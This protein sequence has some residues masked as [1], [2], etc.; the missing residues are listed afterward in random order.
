MKRPSRKSRFESLERRNLL[1]GGL[2]LGVNLP[3]VADYSAVAFVDVMKQAR[4]WQTTD[5]D[6]QGI[7]NSEHAD[8]IDLDASGWPTE[9][10]FTLDNTYDVTEPQIIHT[11]I[12]V[13]GE[14][15]YTF[16]A[17]GTGTV[18]IEAGTGLLDPNTPNIISQTISLSGTVDANGDSIPQQFQFE[19]FNSEYGDGNGNLFL[20]IN[21]SS[22]NDHLREMHLI[23]PG[24]LSDY[25][26]DPFDPT[27]TDD[28]DAFSNLRFMEWQETNNS[29]VV[30]VSDRTLTTD[31]TQSLPSGVAIEYIVDLANQLGQDP[32]ITIPAKAS[33]AYVADMADYLHANLN[34]GLKVFV[35]YSNETWNGA[36]NQAAYIQ[37]KGLALGLSTTS[38]EAGLRYHAMRSAEVWGIFEQSFGNRSSD[39][40]IK[41]IATQFVNIG[42]S[43]QLMAALND[44]TINPGGIM[45]DSLAIGAYFGFSI[46][47]KLV[48]DGTL[49]TATT[50]SIINSLNDELANQTAAD[51]AKQKAVADR[52][53]LWLITYE[54]GQHLA[55]TGTNVQ[56]TDLTNKL[57]AA[58]R[59]PLMG[60][61][62]KNYL[63]LLLAKG[64][65][66][67]SSF[68]YIY[69]P[70]QF[71]SWGLQENQ[72]PTSEQS[73]KYEAVVDWAFANPVSN[74]LPRANAG[75]DFALFDIGNDGENVT[76]DG[77]RSRDFDGT[78]ASYNWIVNGQSVST[79]S[80]FTYDA[81]IGITE[82]TL[83]VTDNDGGVSEDVIT[84]VLSSA[85]AIQTILDANFAAP[86]VN[87]VWSATNSLAADVEYSGFT[88]GSGLSPTST[89]NPQALTFT[90][91][92]YPSEPA[93]L[94]DAIVSNFYISFTIDPNSLTTSA[95]LDL[96]GAPM[97]FTV[98]RV[99]F[100]SARRFA[101]MSSVDGFTTTSDVLYESAAFVDYQPKTT[102][103]F[104]L[105]FD[106]FDTEN[107]IEFRIYMLDGRY[108]NLTNSVT[109]FTSFRLNGSLVRT[110]GPTEIV[111]TKFAIAEN[112]DNVANDIVFAS[113]A[114]VDPTDSDS[115]TF[116]LVT[117]E[118]DDD[119]VRFHIV[120]DQL[121][122]NSGEVVDYE[123]KPD[124]SVRVR[125]TD[126]TGST[127]E[128][129]IDL[130]VIDLVEVSQVLV[131]DGVGAQRSRVTSLLVEFDGVV[132]VDSDAFTI[133]N[134]ATSSAVDYTIS[135]LSNVSG[136]S[137]FRVTFTGVNTE[138]TSLKDGY[139]TLTIDA[140]KVHSVTMNGLDANRNG[141]VNDDYTFGNFEADKFFRLFGDIDGSKSVN[142]I[143]F[144][145][146]QYSYRSTSGSS[147]F[148]VGFDSDNS[149]S[150]NIFD[151][152]K[153]QTQYRKVLTF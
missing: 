135:P 92:N 115:H 74:H 121:V 12:P 126:S 93:S 76:L 52:H 59:S 47:D 9:S 69:T 96:N 120:G 15:I 48:A 22:P 111:E 60:D 81:S 90:T 72:D 109:Y 79:A 102:F 87:G 10:P 38:F 19:I 70:N 29:D 150:I 17:T 131:N 106:G 110:D 107:P 30:D 75:E 95:R 61:V 89:V 137:V 53:G 64:V 49:G 147:K 117:G 20:Y 140:T 152:F 77:T 83:Q 5:E 99:G 80:T 16:I 73:Y 128:K 133:L 97:E 7:Y 129:V 108:N 45:P 151:F 13:R 86:A 31:Y 78:I 8:Q 82:V 36:F 125:V 103:D 32:W 1:A 54:G 42:V 138:F 21:S 2:S 101:V 51:L 25:E 66:L 98:D 24:S 65:V 88:L 85:E 6:R 100:H 146:F 11:V 143:D 41:V 34:S 71:G 130:A 134:K 18:Q 105:P 91:G 144:F 132:T 112:T 142:I 68:N 67:H 23:A 27:Y 114:A 136:K 50:E 26:T 94:Q 37:S 104:R 118:G 84:I 148:Q 116:T 40:L 122:L 3:E 153:F 62:Y 149:G 55:A 123:T 46:A 113:L 145:Q 124:Y 44:P 4:S 141:V 28:L 57:I 33:D 127:L 43:D 14:G 119:N 35:E 58:N 139:H 56:N 39:Q 63:D